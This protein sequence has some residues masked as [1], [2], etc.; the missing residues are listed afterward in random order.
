MLKQG[1]VYVQ[2]HFSIL[3]YKF[4]SQVVGIM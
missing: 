1:N 4:Q 2:Y 3:I